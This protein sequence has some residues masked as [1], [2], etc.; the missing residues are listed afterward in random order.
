[1]LE[2]L[3]HA[4]DAVHWR[5]DLVAHRREKCRFGLV[6]R[7]RFGPR[8][9]GGIALACDGL[10]A[11][12]QL[13]DIAMDDKPFAV[14]QRDPVH[15]DPS[16]ASEVNFIISLRVREPCHPLGQLALNISR[17]V[18]YLAI[19]DLPAEDLAYVAEPLEDVARQSVQL[20]TGI[21]GLNDVAVCLEQRSARR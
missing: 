13:G 9:L 19:L 7:L 15:L 17:T 21:V 3:H 10:L 4:E 18:T 6:G 20:K 8:L 16:S 1:M 5:A 12:L 2:Y 14:R 11:C